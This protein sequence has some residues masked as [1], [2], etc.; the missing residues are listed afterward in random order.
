M[1]HP[2]ALDVDID[3]LLQVLQ[4]ISPLIGNHFKNDSSN[5]R[6]HPE[7]QKGLN[8]H[9]RGSAYF[10]QY[11]KKPLVATC[12]CVACKLGMLLFVLPHSL[13]QLLHMH[14]MMYFSKVNTCA[15]YFFSMTHGY[16]YFSRHAR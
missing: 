8:N 4:K 15:L 11:F 12:D 7:I 14:A 10:R 2:H 9:T 3:A 5:I 13:P 1:T 6:K 16:V